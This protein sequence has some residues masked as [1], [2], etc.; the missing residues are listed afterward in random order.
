MVLSKDT[1]HNSDDRVKSARQQ[2]G[3]AVKKMAEVLDKVED[4]V[5]QTKEN[6]NE[7]RAG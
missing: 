5:T 1:V 7:R 6:L 3:L 2:V 4:V